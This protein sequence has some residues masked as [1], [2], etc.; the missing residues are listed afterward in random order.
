LGGEFAGFPSCLVVNVGRGLGVRAGVGGQAADG[1]NKLL[2]PLTRVG[3]GEQPPQ[4]VEGLGGRDAVGV[5]AGGRLVEDVVDHLLLDPGRAGDGGE[6]A[7]VVVGVGGVATSDEQ[8]SNLAPRRT[9]G[10]PNAAPPNPPNHGKGKQGID[11]DAT[12][13]GPRSRWYDRPVQ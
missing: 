5:G 10:H 11:P 7:R 3:A 13:C 1:V 2:G 4:S 9:H 8:T 6:Q 12:R